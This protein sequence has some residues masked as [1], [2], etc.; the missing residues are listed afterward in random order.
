LDELLKLSSVSSS[1]VWP[2]KPSGSVSNRK[3]SQVKGKERRGEE[4]R[5]EERKGKER[6]G[7]KRNFQSK[8]ENSEPHVHDEDEKGQ[9][10]L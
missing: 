9:R 8:P 2:R 7:K 4:R 6:K 1:S 3:T 10:L 5:G